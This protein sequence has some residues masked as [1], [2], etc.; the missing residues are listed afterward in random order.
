MP[1]FEQLLK[2]GITPDDNVQNARF[3]QYLTN[4]IK[5]AKKPLPEEEFD[6]IKNFI[7]GEAEKL[8]SAIPLAGNYKAKNDIFF[9]GEEMLNLLDSVYEK[10]KKK[11]EWQNVNAGDRYAESV[12]KLIQ[13]VNKERIVE[14]A[15]EE[16]FGKDRIGAADA[17]KVL[18]VVKPLKDEF[19]RGM[20]FEGLLHFKDGIKNFTP[21]AKD[22]F[23]DFIAD[24]AEKIINR[25]AE[26]SESGKLNLE[27]IADICK[28]FPNER[29]F[30]VLNG[31]LKVA[32]NR[33]RYFAVDSL[34]A[35]GKPVPPEVIREMAADTGVACLLYSLLEKHKTL[36]LYPQEFA[37]EEYLAESDMVQW[38]MYPTELG[39]KP[40]KIELLGKTKVKKEIYFIF[41]FMSDSDTLADENKNKWLIGWSNEDGGTFS[42]FDL[43]SDY[44]KKTNEKTVKNIA[45]KLL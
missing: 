44:E 39:K 42:N 9:Y 6:C 12:E 33:T 18:N 35:S 14:N 17:E 16:M 43:L 7:Y 40:D 19:Q 24:E 5:N 38:L 32:E 26:I 4:F 20:I 1:I 37:S 28:D 23:A 36:D 34:L 25:D 31:I 27:Y 15:L 10:T 13:T 8:A 45:K 3:M 30:K 29:I 22:L 21:D 11:T 41:K 2:D